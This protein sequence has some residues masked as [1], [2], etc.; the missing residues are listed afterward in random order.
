MTA[1]WNVASQIEFCNGKKNVQYYIC[2]LGFIQAN[3][4]SLLTTRV[5]FLVVE[6]GYGI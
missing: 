6:M 2:E 1:T 4:G 5:S 3:Y